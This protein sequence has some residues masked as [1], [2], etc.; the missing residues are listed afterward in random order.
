MSL[1]DLKVAYF[2]KYV[3]INLVTNVINNFEIFWGEIFMKMNKLFTSLATSVMVLSTVAPVA[4]ANAAGETGGGETGGET[5]PTAPTGPINPLDPNYANKE[6]NATTGYTQQNS[7]ATVKVVDGILAL[8]T[9][10]SFGFG[11]A[12]AGH[13]KSA[14]NFKSAV[15]NN[16]NSVLSVTESRTSGTT[17]GLGYN[18][19]VSMSG[20]SDADTNNVAETFGGTNWVLNLPRV[21]GLIGSENQGL[22][23]SAADLTSKGDA[24]TVVAMPAK[25]GYGTVDFDYKN[26]TSNIIL[27]VPEEGKLVSDLTEGGSTFQK[28]HTYAATLTWTLNASA[29]SDPSAPTLDSKPATPNP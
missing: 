29:A 16:S 4:V 11:N 10:P 3:K 7:S 15:G 18:V 20:F 8:E 1:A 12:V 5:Q 9:V 19:F 28:N 24:K 17:K 21:S 13:Q 26:D 2:Q 6:Y 27:H 25:N 23:T 14:V 22:H